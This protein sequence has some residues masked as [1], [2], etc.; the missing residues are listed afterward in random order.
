MRYLFKHILLREAA[1]GM[2]FSSHLRQ[3]H[4]KAAEAI[5]AVYAAD[6]TPHYADLVY[7]YSTFAIG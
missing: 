2:Q 6:L 5:E 3:M 4:R 7:H 1:Y